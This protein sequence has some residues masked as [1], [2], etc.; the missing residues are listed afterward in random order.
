MWRR[1][2]AMTTTGK[3]LLA[4]IGIHLAVLL[5]VTVFGSCSCHRA[6][7]DEAPGQEEAAAETKAEPEKP[8]VPDE[9]HDD[10]KKNGE[11]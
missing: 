9:E 8:E 4:V 1:P 7:K 2:C 6:D 11:E 5:C 10:V 3:I